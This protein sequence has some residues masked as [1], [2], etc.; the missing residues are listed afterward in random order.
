MDRDLVIQ[1][2]EQLTE[3]DNNC[4]SE[5][6]RLANE[7]W[8]ESRRLSPR[9][10]CLGTDVRGNKY[11]LLTSRKTVAREFGGYVAIQTAPQPDRP[12]NQTQNL[13]PAGESVEPQDPQ[14]GYSDLGEWWYVDRAADVRQLAKWTMYLASKAAVD[15]ERK[16]AEA[17]RVVVGSPNGKGQ[18][19]AVE[20]VSPVK[21]KERPGPGR[22]IVEA[23]LVDTRALCEQLVHAAEWIEERYELR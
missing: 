10:S 7:L 6:T 4:K 14:D 1:W 8:I 18:R 3:I 16:I 23:G 15:N 9:T 13:S 20:V 12:K 17:R 2:K 5:T 21:L 19:I 11:W 22:K